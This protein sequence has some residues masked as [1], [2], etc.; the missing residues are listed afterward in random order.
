[1]IDP[2]LRRSLASEWENKLDRI[3]RVKLTRRDVTATAWPLWV[4][5]D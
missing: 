4:Q 5:Y 1:M 3:A 2:G